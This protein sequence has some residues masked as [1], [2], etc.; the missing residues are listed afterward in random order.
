MNSTSFLSSLQSSINHAISLGK[1][2]IVFR[3]D[4]V[5][6][7][8]ID[9]ALGCRSLGY[10]CA[11]VMVCHRHYRELWIHDVEVLVRNKVVS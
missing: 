7:P 4:S 11:I 3:Y 5:L 1:E 2:S 10:P 9:C 8:A 6:Y